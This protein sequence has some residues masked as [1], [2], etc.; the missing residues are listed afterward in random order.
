[1]ADR[2]LFYLHELDDYKVASDYPDVRGWQVKDAGGKIVG[3]IDNLLVSKNA[4]RVVYLDVEADRALIEEGHKPLER[5]AREG[6][7]EFINKEGETHLIVPIGLAAVNEDRR[8]VVCER[9]NYDTFRTAKRF[10]KGSSIEPESELT[11]YHHYQPEDTYNT[12][13]ENFYNQ[14]AFRRP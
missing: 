13:D 9:I 3:T 4:K 8:E 5:P 11:V 1:M 10:G 7:H 12:R 6:V 14:S 2:D